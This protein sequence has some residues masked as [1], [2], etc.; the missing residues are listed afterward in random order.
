MA[1]MM[2]RKGKPTVYHFDQ[3]AYD[4]NPSLYDVF[5]LI[6]VEGGEADNVV[7]EQAIDAEAALV[8]KAKSLGI[9]ANRSW[10]IPKLEAAI[11]EAESNVV[12]V[13]DE[14]DL[15]AVDGLLDDKE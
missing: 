15:S 10:G 6:D 5:D 13:V 11:A 4:D 8:K 1:K 2:R 7:V 12:E 9:K 3:A 14:A